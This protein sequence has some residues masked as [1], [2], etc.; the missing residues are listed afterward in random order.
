VTKNPN[1]LRFSV[2][3]APAIVALGLWAVVAAEPPAAPKLATVASAAALTAAA[4]EYLADLG[5]L[6]V[7]EATYTKNKD[8]AAQKAN[9][10]VAL[11]QVLGNHE[12]DSHWK[13]A[14]AQ[15]MTAAAALSRAKDYAAAHAAYEQLVA[16]SKSTV[17]GA[18]PK[19]EKAARL[20]MLMEE[21]QLLNNSLRKG[22]R[23]IERTKESGAR[24]AAVMA[25]FAQASLYD[26]HEVKNEADLPQWYEMAGEMR[27][28]AAELSA[29]YG[30]A[31]EAGTK[32]ALARVEKSCATCHEKFH[33]E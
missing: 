33:N 3:G 9:A 22:L 14:A 30:A 19:W 12:S 6:V 26:T 7:D 20:G 13:P 32:T 27:A 4:D 17:A 28:A 11:A 5:P 10:I 2:V 1:L 18:T 21:V 24:D 16:A 25:A 31:D 15:T 8:Q 29:R 23:R